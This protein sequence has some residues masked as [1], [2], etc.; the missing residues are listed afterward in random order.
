MTSINPLKFG[1]TNQYLKSVSNDETPKKQPQRQETGEKGQKQM[2]S[3]EVLG[4][5]AARNADLIPA[6]TQKTIEVSKFVSPEQ[7]ARIASFMEGFEADYDEAFAAAA[8][9]FEGISDKTASN[10]ALAYINSSY[11]K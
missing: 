7:E 8:N 3:D 4:F 1:I 11:E 9:E 5:L 6:K 10:I 2:G